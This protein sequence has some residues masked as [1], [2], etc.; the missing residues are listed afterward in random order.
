MSNNGGK[1]IKPKSVTIFEDDG[2]PI[3][4][5]R[6]SIMKGLGIEAEDMRSRPFIGI[7]NSWVELNAGHTH[8]RTIAE[9][10]KA[11][12][13]LAGGLPFEF[14][15]PAPCD[16][17][18]NGN[19]GMK[20]ILAQ[21]DLIADIVECY[22]RSQWFDGLITISSCDKINPGMLMAAARLDIPTV[23]IP[24]GSN[25]MNIRFMPNTQSTNH[26]DYDDLDKKL[27]TAT[28]ATCGSCEIMGTANTFQ[29][30]MEV[31]GMALPGSGAVP[32][33]LT[34]KLRLARI[35]GKRIVEMIKENLTP[36]KIMTRKAFEN[37]VMIDL[38]VGGSTNTTLHLPAIA[39]EA[40]IELPLSVFNDFNTK[41]PTLSGVNPNGPY[42]MNDF[43]VAGGVPAVMKQLKDDLHT[44]CMTVT[45]KTVGE[46]LKYAAVLNHEVI[47]PKSKPFSTLG[48]TVILYGNLAPEGAVV[49]QSAVHPSMHTFRGT[50]KVFESEKEA[51]QGFL[52]DQI[53]EGM[54]IVIRYEGPKGAPGMPELLSLTTMMDVMG[55][56]RVGLITD[57]RFSGATSGPCVGHIS[58]E[59]YDGGPIAAL[60]DGDEILIDI[61]N[62]KLEVSL[63]DEE[64]KNRLKNFAPLEKPV[65]KGY[66]QRYRKLV[67]SPATGAIVNR[68]TKQLEKIFEPVM[69]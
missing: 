20:F 14:N 40:G 54:V 23:C 46:N 2:V 50:A 24:G 29:C 47:R 37:A 44:D 22:A 27:A 3:G 51:T 48:G 62:R 4:L 31:L 13:L 52:S 7:A 36:S 12:V 66:M 55:F 42:G 15:V 59:A 10:V 8:L 5:V 43:F 56:E 28:C 11:G 30:L 17:I 64:I 49:K 1:N 39:N 35:A 18:G 26:K 63:T 16:G 45:G 32:S 60:R 58:P 69:K 67:S 25:A 6:M 57:G 33:Y 68:D 19:D 34:E 41:I 38:A 21:R 65:A 9:H 53:K 61:P